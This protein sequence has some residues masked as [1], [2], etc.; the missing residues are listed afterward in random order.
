MLISPHYLVRK[1]LPFIKKN[2]LALSVLCLSTYSSLA[3]EQKPQPDFGPTIKQIIEQTVLPGYQNL[4]QSARVEEQSIKQLCARPSAQNLG[5]ARENFRFLVEAWSSIEIYRLGPAVQNN[6]QEKLFF[7]PDRKSI[8]LRQVRKLIDSEDPKALTLDSLQGKSVAVQGLL[9]LEYVLFG[10]G[11]EDLTAAIPGSY[12]C[13]YGATISRA[14]GDT[15]QDISDGWTVPNGY[16]DLMYNAGPQN[17]VY[18]S[19]G[20]VIQ[21]FLRVASEMIQ[22]TRDL[23]IHNTIKSEP[24]KSKPKRAP[25]WRSDLTLF[26]FQENLKSVDHLFTT[27]G[28][29]NFTPRYTK[30]LSFELEQTNIFLERL[31]AKQETWLDIVKQGES[32]EL[33]TFVLIPLKGAQYVTADLI[34]QQLGLNLGFNS[35][36]G[37]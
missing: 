17:P 13:S 30:S 29:G 21:D 20:E 3:Q 34:P 14:I 36:D 28:L 37:D 7:W 32:H 5:I 23:K 26:A 6:R 11:S 2:F 15:A 16:A 19:Q 9:A 1:H 4:E 12:R 22:S 10:K 25:L 35:L 8:G 27:G 18:R 31:D 24:A 33:L